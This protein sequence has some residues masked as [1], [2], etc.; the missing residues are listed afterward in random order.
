M[1][2]TVPQRGAHQRSR[3]PRSLVTRNELPNRAWLSDG[4]FTL[5]PGPVADAVRRVPAALS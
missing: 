2:L 5:G 4:R 3:V 1:L